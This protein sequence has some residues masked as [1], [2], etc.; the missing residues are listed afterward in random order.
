MKV[1]QIILFL[2][3]LLAFSQCSESD[4]LKATTKKPTD[5]GPTPQPAAS[6]M[7]TTNL[8]PIDRG[9]VPE[10]DTIY[11]SWRPT[12]DA[13]LYD[14]YL[15]RLPGE[16]KLIASDLST[17]SYEFVVPPGLD[18]MYQ[19]YVRAKKVNGDYTGCNRVITTFTTKELPP[20]DEQQ[21]VV[22]V[23]VL[24]FDPKLEGTNYTVRQSYYWQ[25]PKKLAD[26][27]MHDVLVSSHNLIKYNIVDW[28]D[29]NAFPAKADGF[30]YTN[31]TYA[32]VMKNPDRHHS[33][34]DLDY[35][36]MIKDQEIVEGINDDV[37]EEVWIFG[38]PYFGFWESAMAGPKAFYINGNYFSDVRSKKAFV[39]MGFSYER[40]VAEMLHDLCH[41]SEATLSLAYVSWDAKAPRNPWEKF[42]A[43]ATQSHGEANVGSCHY[44][45]NALADYDYE[46]PSFVMSAADDWYNYP[47]LTGFKKNVNKDSWGGSDYE[48]NYL[49]W[50][51]S[52]LP[53]RE[54]TGPYGK[55]NNWW[56]YI[57]EYNDTIMPMRL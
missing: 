17:L 52:H 9:Y 12:T 45:P 23:L 25:D 6:R 46:N 24:N 4:D 49:K 54:G 44:P 5:P 32:A 19:W 16:P 35:Y 40:G 28:R 21:K 11:L 53:R 48:R 55:L 30:V 56:R 51:F 27:Y 43:N 15:G 34:D 7:C 1:N 42:A 22:N 47:V 57:F 3:S 26:G 10:N 13:S 20:L 50:W 29:I 18:S 2:I 8:F 38:A 41:R 36:K 39:I 14:V 37:F 33:P 31:E